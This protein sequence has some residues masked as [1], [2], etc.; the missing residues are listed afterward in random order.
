MAHKKDATQAD[1]DNL[2]DELQ[3]SLL[4]AEDIKALRAKVSTLVFRLRDEKEEKIRLQGKEATLKRKLDML[5]D[6][7]EKLMN[8]LRI[9]SKQKCRVVESRRSLR[10]ELVTMREIAD[11]QQKIIESKNRYIAEISEGSKL[12]E[13]Q[14]RLMDDKYLEMR[15]KL[16]FA[17]EQ[18]RVEVGRA[19]RSASSLRRKFQV[20]TGSSKLLDRCEIPD[21]TGPES[22]DPRGVS[23]ADFSEGPGRAS[24]DAFGKSTKPPARVRSAPAKRTTQGTGSSHGQSPL[25]RDDVPDLDNILHKIEKKKSASEGTKWNVAKMKNLLNEAENLQQPKTGQKRSKPPLSVEAGGNP[26][27]QAMYSKEFLASVKFNQA[28][29]L[30]PGS[31]KERTPARASSFAVLDY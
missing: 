4:A 8:H 11:R 24:P 18:S 14:L 17:R 13:D 12:L 2:K 27:S 31:S 28:A 7:L 21:S 16:D 9:E 22:R 23:W 1:F 25:C 29:E 30:S 6:H 3:V 10:K 15:K 5:A 19:E 26:G 20:L